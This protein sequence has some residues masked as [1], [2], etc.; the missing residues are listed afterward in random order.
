MTN[1]DAIILGI[2][3]GFTEFLPISSS[4]HL[5]LMQELLNLNLPGNQL[6]VVMHAGTLFSILFVFW[7]DLVTLTMSLTEKKSLTYVT[8][9]VVGTIPAVIVGLGF[10]SQIES[11]FDS[12]LVVGINLLF[13]GVLLLATRFI[14]IKDR[15]I[16]IKSSVSIGLAQAL[17]ILPGISRS[18]STISLALI[19][20]IKPSEAARFSFLL[21]IP[22][23]M[24]AGLLT[25]LDGFQASGQ[26]SLM[27]LI[28]GFTTS[29]ATGWVALKWLLTMLKKGQFYWFGAYCFI[30]GTLTIIF[31]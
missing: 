24:G 14:Q 16:S 2:V 18:G 15:E 10:K 1:F 29:F 12:T 4:G 22:A 25:A 13:T 30:I 19:M 17:A 20:G 28:L 7:K 5:V 27:P 26:T 6:E 9:V 21:A 3:Q 11:M 8:Y 31:L 23:L